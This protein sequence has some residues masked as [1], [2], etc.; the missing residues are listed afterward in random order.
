MSQRIDLLVDLHR[1]Q[2]GRKGRPRAPGEDDPRHH[3]AHLPRDGQPDQVG[4]IDLRPKFPQLHGADKRQDQAHQKANEGHNPQR[5]RPTLLEEE[6]QIDTPEAGL[7]RHQAEA[8][9]ARCP[10]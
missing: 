4:D 5:L 10:Q 3:G 8:R 7:P 6:H 1:A 9:P 2:L